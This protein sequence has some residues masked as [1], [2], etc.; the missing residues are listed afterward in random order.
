MAATPG[1]VGLDVDIADCILSTAITVARWVEAGSDQHTVALLTASHRKSWFTI[2]GLEKVSAFVAGTMA[3]TSL[4][5]IVF[6]VAMARITTMIDRRLEEQ[7]L[8]YHLDPLPAAIHFDRDFLDLP[9]KTKVIASAWIDDLAVPVVCHAPAL[10]A[11]STAVPTE[12]WHVL[13]MFALQL[14]LKPG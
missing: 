13:N 2:D 7:E 9:A 3:G 12:V 4:A 8:V 6:V 1:L 11:K 14:N 10:V 5:D